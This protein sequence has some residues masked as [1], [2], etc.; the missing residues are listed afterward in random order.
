MSTES[1]KYHDI[2]VIGIVDL[3][4]LGTDLEKLHDELVALKRVH[5]APNQR[6]VVQYTE[7]D[8]FFHDSRVGFT[9]H[10]FLRILYHV[11]ISLSQIT[12]VTTNNRLEESIK[13]FISHERDIPEIHVVLV[14]RG[15]YYNIRNI[16]SDTE[17]PS[18]DLKHV[19]LCM[20]GT[21][22]EHRIRLYQY[23]KYNNL[24][25]KIQTSFN[26]KKNPVLSVPGDRDQISKT[27]SN[28]SLIDLV[29]SFP[30]RTVEAWCKPVI[31]DEIKKYQHVSIDASLSNPNIPA[32]GHKFYKEFAL[33]VVTETNFHYPSQFVS[34]KT[35]RPLLLKTPFLVFGPSLFL[36]YLQHRGFQTFGDLWD[37]SYD[38][39]DNPQDRF[40]KC[41][42]V[43]KDLANIPLSDWNKLYQQ[44]NHRL[45][46][47]RQLL[48]QYIKND[49][50]LIHNKYKL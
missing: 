3:N 40:V 19:G 32:A 24:L 9:I 11:D 22:R 30:S 43:L 5:Y 34:E 21:V 10:N 31:N 44:I 28:L 36:K 4:L 35:L 47:N 6:I 16:L 46:H 7:Q 26:N 45:D 48:L 23:L 37:E 25:D 14:S 50:I 38:I 33:D 1:I 39:I 20:L 2:D 8:Y 13:P 17:L 42:N 12:F 29:Y 18:K 15:T 27:K 41:C 49:F